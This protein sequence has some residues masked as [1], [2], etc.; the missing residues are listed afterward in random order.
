MATS[1]IYSLQKPV[2]F[3]TVFNECFGAREILAHILRWSEIG[4]TA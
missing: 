4:I 3:I 1:I 2:A